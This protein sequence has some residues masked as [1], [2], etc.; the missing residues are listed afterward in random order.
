MIVGLSTDRTDEPVLI[1]MDLK[2]DHVTRMAQLK[3]YSR[4]I[5]ELCGHVVRGRCWHKF[6]QLENVVLKVSE[7]HRRIVPKEKEQ[8][9]MPS[10]G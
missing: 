8:H 1:Y 3:L 7:P 2:H 9:K 5:L 6:E 10:H 4:P